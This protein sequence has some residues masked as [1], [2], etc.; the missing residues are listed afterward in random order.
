MAEVE[1]MEHED[2]ERTEQVSAEEPQAVTAEV[3]AAF[4]E[5]YTKTMRDMVSKIDG[6][7]KAMVNHGGVVTEQRNEPEPD[8]YDPYANVKTFDQL[9]FTI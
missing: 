4:Q 2:V 7:A 1:N 6:L 3:F 8:R 9:D 5:E